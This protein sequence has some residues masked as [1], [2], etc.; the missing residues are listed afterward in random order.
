MTT[1]IDPDNRGCGCGSPIAALVAI[2]LAGLW[3]LGGYFLL[4]AMAYPGGYEAEGGVAEISRRLG[5]IAYGPPWVT[6]LLVILGVFPLPLPAV[7][8]RMAYSLSP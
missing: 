4:Y 8:R 5:W 7:R 2:F 3:A 1:G 6:I